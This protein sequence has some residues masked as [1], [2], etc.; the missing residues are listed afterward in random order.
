M[1]VLNRVGKSEISFYNNPLFDT[2]GVSLF[3]LGET[4]D[5]YLI[6]SVD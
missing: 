5:N 6:Q 4:F 1:E 3:N 2:S